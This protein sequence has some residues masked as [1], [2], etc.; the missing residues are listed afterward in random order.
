MLLSVIS[1]GNLIL[2]EKS[3][4]GSFL[5]GVQLHFTI[6]QEYFFFDGGGL[7]GLNI[8]Y[9]DINGELTKYSE[10]EFVGN[11]EGRV[12]CDYRPDGSMSTKEVVDYDEFAEPLTKV[13]YE[14]DENENL[15]STAEYEIYD[16]ANGIWT[17]I[18]VTFEED[19]ANTTNFVT[20]M[21]DVVLERPRTTRDC[22]I[23]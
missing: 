7:A 16:Q 19:F 23:G 12:A 1:V 13:V 14:Y 11:Y 18:S 10:I 8:E 15:I 20:R 22:C 4:R 9:Y 5:F 3:R 2:P 6:N 21:Y 17:L